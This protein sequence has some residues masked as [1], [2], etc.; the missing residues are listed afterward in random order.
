MFPSLIN[1]RIEWYR[2]SDGEPLIHFP[3]TLWNVICTTGRFYGDTSP[4]TAIVTYIDRLIQMNVKA[5]R[6]DQE[7]FTLE[8]HLHG[9][10]DGKEP[11]A[12]L[13]FPRKA[14]ARIA[15]L[16]DTTED[17]VREVIAKSIVQSIAEQ[18]ESVAPA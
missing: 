4:H 18:Y 16:W 15:E 3:P 9:E 5:D 17:E 7:L 6:T 13:L 14:L 12:D 10:S 2:N 11:Q 8:W 1:L